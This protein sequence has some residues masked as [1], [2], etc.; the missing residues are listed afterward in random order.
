MPKY[1]IWRSEAETS[2]TEINARN[3]SQVE[4]LL[5]DGDDN[6]TWI[7]TRYDADYEIVNAADEPFITEQRTSG[8]A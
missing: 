1:R 2:Y 3:R 6:F 4:H 8:D 7:G 5:E